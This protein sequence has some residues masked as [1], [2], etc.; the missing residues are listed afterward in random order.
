MA[1]SNERSG[2]SIITYTP[3]CKAEEFIA[4]TRQTFIQTTNI[5][6]DHNSRYVL[7]GPIE[8]TRICLG[9]FYVC[10]YA[11]IQMR[12][13]PILCFH[14]I[15]GGQISTHVHPA[16]PLPTSPGFVSK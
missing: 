12:V 1:L 6:L 8:D 5:S 9:K 13:Q 4:P 2:Q 14:K 10:C 11:G 3:M 16:H 7:A 15:L